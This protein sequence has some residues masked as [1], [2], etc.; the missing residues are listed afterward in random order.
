VEGDAGVTADDPGATSPDPG[1]VRLCERRLRASSGGPAA[2][3]GSERWGESPAERRRVT[4]AGGSE[5]WAGLIARMGT[6]CTEARLT[7]LPR[8]ELARAARRGGPDC[9][10][11]VP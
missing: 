4:A 7:R 5:L 6:G 2:L 1:A 11:P 3:S 8:P 10:V 9:W